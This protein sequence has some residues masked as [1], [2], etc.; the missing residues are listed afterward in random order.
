MDIIT[1]HQQ[2]LIEQLDADAS[3]LAGRPGDHCQR[4]VVLYHLFDHSGGTHEWALAEA[5]RE[6]RLAAAFIALRC[7]VRR[8]GWALPRRE[9]VEEGIGRLAQ[10]V[11]E[12]S[13]ARC[14]AAYRA[15]R[16]T[17]S[18]PLTGEAER[19]LAPCLFDALRQCH[20]AR[21]SGEAMAGSDRQSLYSESEALAASC[22]DELALAAAWGVVE[23]TL[24]GRKARRLVGARALARLGSPGTARA[25]T[26][27][28]RWVRRN[29][30]LPGSFRANPAQHF[31]A[32]QFALA[33][34]RLKVQRDLCD[35]E[36]GSFELAA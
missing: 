16:M 12:G 22:V 15:Y 4:A 3:S 33:Q 10:R 30:L 20:G 13:Q 9:Q 21:R 36:P 6:L 23:A 31:F 5:V 19:L 29:R 11:G 14:V 25:R 8:W 27:M 26:R 28:E 7:W 35:W 18:A 24:A 32:L 1:A 2:G 17:A 34:R